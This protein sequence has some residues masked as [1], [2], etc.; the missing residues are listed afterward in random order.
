MQKA[1]THHASKGGNGDTC[2][3]RIIEKLWLWPTC[4]VPS[5]QSPDSKQHSNASYINL[6]NHM[7]YTP[8]CEDFGPVNLAA[9]YRFC[10][11]IESE[12]C[13]TCRTAPSVTT[14]D[15]STSPPF[16]DSVLLWNRIVGLTKT[17]TWSSC[18]HPTSRP[19]QTPPSSSAPT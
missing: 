18:R 3:Q 2:P 6:D 10:F 7:P 16:T 15:P 14:S 12:F 17:A 13:A 4:R 19:S 11:M 8:F 1:S 9:V 5:L